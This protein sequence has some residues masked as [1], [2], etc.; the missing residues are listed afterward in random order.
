MQNVSVF[1]QIIHDIKTILWEK[2]MAARDGCF[3]LNVQWNFFVVLNHILEYCRII[4]GHPIYDIQFQLIERIESVKGS[5][6]IATIH[7]VHNDRLVK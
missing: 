7:V 5:I 4:T 6:E 1:G 2:Q 3:R